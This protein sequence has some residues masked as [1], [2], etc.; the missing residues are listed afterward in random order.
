MHRSIHAISSTKKA[1]ELEILLQK[2]QAEDEEFSKTKFYKYR[3]KLLPREVEL[4]KKFVGLF[5]DLRDVIIEIEDFTDET[6]NAGNCNLYG[7]FFIEI[8]D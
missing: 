6:F 2:F 4:V 1:A 7:M 5:N 8:Y 3:E